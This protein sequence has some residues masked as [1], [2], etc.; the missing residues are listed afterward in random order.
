[1]AYASSTFSKY[2]AMCQ[3]IVDDLNADDIKH[4]KF[5]L[6]ST[7]TNGELENIEDGQDLITTLEKRDLLSQ[8]NVSLLHN[9]LEKKCGRLAKIVGAYD[10]TITPQRTYNKDKYDISSMNIVEQFVKTSAADQV[11]DLLKNKGAAFI[12]GPNGVGKSQI[13]FWYAN[14]FYK[15]NKKSV[16]WRI[17][18]KSL[19]STHLSLATLLS[20]L[21][22]YEDHLISQKVLSQCVTN[23]FDIVLRT[24]ESEQWQQHQ[25]LIVMDDIFN[26]KDDIMYE[27]LQRFINLKN[28]NLLATSN[29]SYPTELASSY[30]VQISGMTP[31]EAISLLTSASEDKDCLKKLVKNLNYLPLAI[32]LASS[33]IKTTKISIGDY[34]RNISAFQMQAQQ[35]DK[36]GQNLQ[37]S[38]DMTLQNV[39]N[40][41]SSHC[42]R[43]LS[44]IPYLSHTSISV[45]VLKTFLPEEVIERELE[46]TNLMSALQNYSLA[47]ARRSG[48]I[49]L[50]EM[51]G[52][53]VWVL[54]N[55]KSSEQEKEDLLWLL[56]H[57]CREMAID[58]RLVKNGNRNMEFLDHACLLMNKYLKMLNNT[59]DEVLVYEAYLALCI[60]STFR[61]YGRTEITAEDFFERGRKIIAKLGKIEPSIYPVSSTTNRS[62]GSCFLMKK[63]TGDMENFLKGDEIIR[64]RACQIFS[65]LH[66]VHTCITEEMLEHLVMKKY[67]NDNEMSIILCNTSHIDENM[68]RWIPD[69]WKSDL[70]KRGL[71]MPL[72]ELRA[73]FL[74]ELLTI[75]LYNSNG[76]NWWITESEAVHA[77]VEGRHMSVDSK[78]FAEF[79][80]TYN[81]ACI[82]NTF[83]EDRYPSFRPVIAN[84]IKRSGVLYYVRNDTLNHTVSEMKNV[85]T[86]LEGMLESSPVINILIGVINMHSGLDVH[87][88]CHVLELLRECYIKLSNIDENNQ[89]YYIT[90]ALAKTS[91]LESYIED[92]EPW[93]L[94]PRMHLAIADMC[95]RIKTPSMA[96]KAK[97]HFRLAIQDN[98]NDEITRYTLKSYK[99]YIEFCISQGGGNDLEEA[100]SLCKIMIE[101]FQNSSK[102]S[103]FKQKCEIINELKKTRALESTRHKNR[104]DRPFIPYQS[105]L[106]IECD[107][108]PEQI[109]PP[110][111][112]GENQVSTQQNSFR[113]VVE[114]RLVGID[115]E[116]L[117]VERE[118][119]D[120]RLYIERERHDERLSIERERLSIEK[121]RLSIEK[122]RLSIENEKLNDAKK[123]NEILERLVSQLQNTR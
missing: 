114:E 103:Y 98:A 104:N 60:G 44:L 29:V 22:N 31:E 36:K 76:N 66:D 100:E 24:L 80:L 16:I 8:K 96:R 102:Y 116:R 81:M 1:M 111:Y 87:H 53:S 92:L 107:A 78:C 50:L 7:L 90:Q 71:I 46:I 69:V 85:I 79:Q 48:N 95:V 86:F 58:V 45:D 89:N 117:S 11:F 115:S 23:M 94:L 51:H 112:K 35:E 4:L 55:K 56:K 57:Y 99:C 40:N 6:R 38:Y 65:A 28:V 88:T 108:V 54:K 33:Y 49:R 97:K 62:S 27:M 120:E 68:G 20:T 101:K 110:D 32:S 39:E 106:Q 77:F 37:A 93:N 74:I 15:E 109:A 61:I 19:E 119:H 30:E 41:L 2:N 121:E 52:L 72:H 47:S 9:L 21:N 73:T 59:S 118:R 67:R 18:S 26:P 17:N 10:L 70:M 25:H 42:K 5:S 34:L 83:Y 82:L 105:K 113:S 64:N 43:V 123:T 3:I 12:K 75:L 14:Q 13:A 84:V 91:L 122:E 63:E